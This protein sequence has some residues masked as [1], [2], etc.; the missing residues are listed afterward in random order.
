MTFFDTVAQLFQH[1]P[2]A[3]RA[4]SWFDTALLFLKH[5]ISLAGTI[6]IFSG[7]CVAFVRYVRSRT[8]KRLDSEFNSIRLNLGQTI[9]LGLEFIVAADVIETTIAPDYYALGIVIIVVAIRMMLSM[10]LSK[11]IEQDRVR[12]N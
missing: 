3:L 10:S 1:N 8:Y 2:D 5:L 4:E 11:E 9:L 6:I 12:Q 7:T